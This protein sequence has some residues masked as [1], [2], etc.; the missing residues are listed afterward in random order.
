MR[1]GEEMENRTERRRG[2][3]RKREDAEN[4]KRERGEGGREYQR[5]LSTAGRWQTVTHFKHTHTHTRFLNNILTLQTSKCECV[6][7]VG[8]VRTMTFS[9]W[10]EEIYKSHT[11]NNKLVYACHRFETHTYTLTL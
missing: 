5:E 9:T 4:N 2:R 3:K 7:S 6:Y 8:S 10:L 11:V 1:K